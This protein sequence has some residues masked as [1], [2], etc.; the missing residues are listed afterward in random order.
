MSLW[1]DDKYAHLL[2]ASLERFTPKSSHIY[3][4]RCPFCGDSQ[5]NRYKSRAYFYPVKQDIMMKCHNCSVSMKLS[6]FLK[7]T[8]PGLYHEYILEKIRDER[9]EPE[10]VPSAASLAETYPTEKLLPHVYRT[11]DDAGKSVDAY[12]KTRGISLQGRLR[13]FATDDAPSWLAPLVGDEKAGKVRSGETYLVLPMTY[14]DGTWFGAQLRSLREKQYITFR[15]NTHESLKVFGLSTWNATQ[16]TFLV[17][18]PLDAVCIT[19]GLAACGSDLCETVER[20]YESKMVSPDM[21]PVLVWDNEPRNKEVISHIRRAV[22]T[23][24]KVVIWPVGWPYKDINDSIKDSSVNIMDVLT[25]R[26]FRGLQAQLE[27]AQ[28]AR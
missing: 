26:T 10:P 19:N 21:E 1:L 18:G 9:H 5:R 2:S 8:H 12:L 24:W 13:C 15:W 14:C 3:N 4:F 17:E 11:S 7:Q 6:T 16:P 28:W 27:L 20:L 23:N 25:S 22:T